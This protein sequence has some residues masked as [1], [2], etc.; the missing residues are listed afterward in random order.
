MRACAK[1]EEHRRSPFSAA[2]SVCSV[3]LHLEGDDQYAMIRAS[4][5]SFARIILLGRLP[6]HG[7]WFRS[8]CRAPSVSRQPM[9]A[10]FAKHRPSSTN[11]GRLGPNLVKFGPTFFHFRPKLAQP[12]PTAATLGRTCPRSPK[13]AP[14][15]TNEWLSARIP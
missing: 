10:N 6:I 1:V 9:W 2:V 12:W 5:G 13:I 4:G 15:R 11:N 3:V 7:V 14:N 8:A